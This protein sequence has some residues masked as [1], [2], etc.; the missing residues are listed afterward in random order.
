MTRE[1]V[2]ELFR[3]HG[4]TAD[5]VFILLVLNVITIFLLVEIL[6]SRTTRR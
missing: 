4:H 1:I 3:L 5:T 2:A 6:R